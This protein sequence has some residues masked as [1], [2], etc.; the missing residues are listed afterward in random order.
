[1]ESLSIPDALDGGGPG[2]KDRFSVLARAVFGLSWSLEFQYESTLVAAVCDRSGSVA[3]DV[4]LHTHSHG[5]RD[6]DGG[7]EFPLL[8]DPGA[9]GQGHLQIRS[10]RAHGLALHSEAAEGTS[11]AGD[12]FPTEAAGR[13]ASRRRTQPAG[14]PHGRADHEPR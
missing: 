4:G 10:R 2:R 13:S 8:P 6:G 5:E 14:L 3:T 1:G 7:Q 11:S 12:D 9:E